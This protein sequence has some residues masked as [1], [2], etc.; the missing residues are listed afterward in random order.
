MA[1]VFA[2]I[3]SYF[4]ATATATATGALTAETAG[5]VAAE[6]AFASSTLFTAANMQMI[7]SGL[8]AVSSIYQGQQ[9][10]EAYRLQSQQAALKGRQDALQYNRRAFQT[11][12]ANDRLRSALIARAAAGG[13]DPFTGSPMSLSQAND[14]AAY[15]E[16]RIDR[17]NAEMALYGGLGQSQALQAAASTAETYGLLK[18]AADAAMGGARFM[19]TKLPGVLS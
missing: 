16:A 5:M 9:Q 2:A 1:A 14:M 10:A 18:G 13:V 4:G 12:Q 7:G 6:S 19:D 3:G 8:S 11:L 15:E 17:E